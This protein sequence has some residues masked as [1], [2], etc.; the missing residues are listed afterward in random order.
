M[1]ALLKRGQRSSAV[2]AA[3]GD[4]DV[5]AAKDTALA[6]HRALGCD[7]LVMRYFLSLCQCVPFIDTGQAHQI[8]AYRSAERVLARCS[9]I[10]AVTAIPSLVRSR[11]LAVSE[12]CNASTY[13]CCRQSVRRP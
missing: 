3:L 10:D 9:A 1:K 4:G 11:A 2:W 12:S 6:V 5:D 13:R 7:K 8:E